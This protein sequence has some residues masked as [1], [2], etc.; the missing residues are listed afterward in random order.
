MLKYAAGLC[1]HDMYVC[2]FWEEKERD[3]AL[4]SDSVE[5]EQAPW[6]RL[7]PCLLETGLV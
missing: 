7:F 1:R 3:C 2:V 6:L 4:C 5:P